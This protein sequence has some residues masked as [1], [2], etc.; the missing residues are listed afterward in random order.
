M[1]EISEQKNPDK[2]KEEF[3]RELDSTN[4]PN[5]V[6]YL[7]DNEL[8]ELGGSVLYYPGAGTDWEPI[9]TFAPNSHID[10][11]VFVDYMKTKD[12]VMK[13]LKDHSA[14]EI[15]EVEDLSPQDFGK[16]DWKEFWAS[17]QRLGNIE[18]VAGYYLESKESNNLFACKF[19]LRLK[20][21]KEVDLYYIHAD[22][23]ETFKVLY[24][25]GWKIRVLLVQEHGWGGNWDRF[26]EGGA[27]EYYNFR[28]KPVPYIYFSFN[29]R[30]YEGYEQ[31]TAFDGMNRN[32]ALF[33]KLPKSD[34]SMIRK[35]KRFLMERLNEREIREMI[36]V[37]ERLKEKYP[38]MV[39][40]VDVEWEGF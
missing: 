6:T 13:S 28:L 21:N 30:A 1:F 8:E 27:L 38:N 29:S 19:R 11:F 25:H 23:I 33:K 12:S 17:N 16:K 20:S 24:E 15:L 14:W 32:R 36:R 2:I 4:L 40:V 31:I 34:V 35:R 7:K 22:G 10:T 39:K 9:L 37:R 3:Q 5:T 26:G 18:R